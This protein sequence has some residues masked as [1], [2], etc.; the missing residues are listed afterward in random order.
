[1]KLRNLSVA[2]AIALATPVVAMAGDDVDIG[3][4]Y[5]DDFR[6]NQDTITDLSRDEI[7]LAGMRMFTNPFLKQ[8]GYG[9]GDDNPP[10]PTPGTNH[11]GERGTLQGNGTFQR[12]NGLDAQACLECHSIISRRKVPMTFGIGGVGGVNNNVLGAGGATFVDLTTSDKQANING[13]VINPPFIFG[14][15]G[16]ELLAK[17]M[18]I[19]LNRQLQHTGPN[20]TTALRAKSVDFG[21]VSKDAAGNIVTVDHDG[22]PST[23]EIADGVVGVF[24]LR[25]KRYVDGALVDNDDFL[26]VAPFGRKG[27]NK[28]T[29]TFDI[30]ALSFHF[31]MQIGNHDDDNDGISNEVTDGELSALSVFVATAQTPFQTELNAEARRGRRVMNEVGCTECHKPKMNTHSKLLTFSSDEVGNDPT[32]AVYYSVDLTKPPMNFPKNNRGGVTVELF[33]DLKRHYMGPSLAEFNGDAMFTT[34]RLWGVADTAPYLHDGRALTIPDAIREHGADA[35]SEANP[36]VSA[37]LARSAE[38]QE[39]V[40]AFLDT[41]RSPDGTFPR[42]QRLAKDVA[43]VQGV[44]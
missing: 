22:D 31:G 7:R 42:L 13:R 24:D 9:D 38:D 26:V 16:I 43:T 10:S 36:A 28:S 37:F 27:D 32:H 33:A 34:M 35:S 11:E 40:L 3:K 18:T 2:C 5:R 8:E 30:G 39:A 14:A 21:S 29:R 12:I 25:P 41:L 15:G 19:R 4:L 1:M 6:V 44:D 17:E 20:E 23:E